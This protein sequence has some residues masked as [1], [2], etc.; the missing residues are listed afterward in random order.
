MIPRPQPGLIPSAVRPVSFIARAVPA[1]CAIALTGCQQLI[2]PKPISVNVETRPWK[3]GRTEGKL[4]VTPHYDIHTTLKDE[5]MLQ[6]LPTFLETAHQLYTNLLPRHETSDERSSLFVFQDRNQW[7]RFTRQF[8]PTRAETYLRIRSGGYAEPRGTVIYHL[9]R[10]NYTLAVIA[11]ECL[12]MYVYRNFPPRTVPPWLNEGLACYCE[13]YEW[14]DLTPVFTP[15]ENRFRMNAVRRA[16]ARGTLLKLKEMLATDAGKMLLFSPDL[17]E[18]YYAQAW[19][20][21]AFMI[22]GGKYDKAFMRMRQELGTDRMRQA[23]SGYIAAYPNSH[24]QPMSPGEAL[25]RAYIT[26]DLERF[27]AEYGVWLKK[28]SQPEQN[29]WRL[30]TRTP[31]PPA[32]KAP[33]SLAGDCLDENLP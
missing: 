29:P 19:S 10:R 33:I 2:P 14:H 27:S 12:H 15:G 8:A 6:I 20:L 5:T 18:T 30:F 28:L 17:V 11:H 3:F 7:D 23:M 21:V 4:F 13:G 22:H 25:F 9:R 16:L 26:D 32:E 24:G 31:N 1:L